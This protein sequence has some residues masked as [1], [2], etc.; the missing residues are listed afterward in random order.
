MAKKKSSILKVNKPAK[1]VAP[2]RKS[3]VSLL[4]DAGYQVDDAKQKLGEEGYK[5]VDKFSN[6]NHSVFVDKEDNPFIVHRGTQNL[7]DVVADAF[8]LTGLE[9]F[10]PRFREAK[11]LT[12]KVRLEYEKPVTVLGHSLGG[13]LAEVSG[14]D[15]I[16]TVNKGVGLGGIGKI[17]PENQ[18]DL[19]R[20]GDVVSALS[21]LQ[22]AH[23]KN[24]SSINN[25]NP[26]LLHKYGSI[27]E[28]DA[29]VFV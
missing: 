23:K 10:H 12:R 9:Q 6:R 8:V 16:I 26:L 13:S 14:G 29:N 7:S 28:D 25:V 20:R 24:Q 19:R 5:K 21:N 2:L 3:T 4:L 15:K 1:K 17:I 22:Y 18:I 11:R 27:L